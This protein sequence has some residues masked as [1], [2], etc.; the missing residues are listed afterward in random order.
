MVLLGESENMP[1]AT[2]KL[3][4][5]GV[6]DAGTRTVE[7]VVFRSQHTDELF[8]H[9]VDIGQQTPQEGWLE[10]DPKEILKAIDVCVKAVAE[11]LPSKGYK[12]SDIV[13]IGIT[14]QRETT[15]VW[16]KTTGEP[17]YNAIGSFLL[18]YLAIV[19]D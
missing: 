19:V 16:D 2:E 14:N 7:F 11:K 9:E 17:L 8:T 5:I 6:I 15:I 4:L 3:P 10:Q 12:I 1:V 18:H 13:T